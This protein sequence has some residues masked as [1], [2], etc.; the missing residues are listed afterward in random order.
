MKDPEIRK[1]WEAFVDAH[2]EVFEDNVT[3]WRRQLRNLQ[4]FIQAR[5][6]DGGQQQPGKRPSDN[7]KDPDEKKLAQWMQYQQHSYA[8]NLHIMKDPVVRKEWQAF[9]DAHSELFEDNVT[10]WRRNLRS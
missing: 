10:K 3:K 8:R 9:V 1:E 2:S 5:S 6:G 7:S 4:S